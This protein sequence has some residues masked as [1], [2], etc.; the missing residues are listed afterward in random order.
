MRRPR[1]ETLREC[2][3]PRAGREKNISAAKTARCS[4]SP[5]RTQAGTRTAKNDPP[6]MLVQ[7]PDLGR[8]NGERIATVELHKESVKHMRSRGSGGT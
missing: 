3:G 8:K 7:Q 6:H 2:I 1:D 5:L 4:N